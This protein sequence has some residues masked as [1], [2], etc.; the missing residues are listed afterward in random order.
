MYSEYSYEHTSIYMCILLVRY[1]NL[2]YYYPVVFKY[3]FMH[4]GQT[5]V[6]AIS[7]LYIF[8]IDKVDIPN[9][10]FLKK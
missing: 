6:L 7:T 8:C 9:T 10:N 5:I 4:I 2:D 1:N 3:Y